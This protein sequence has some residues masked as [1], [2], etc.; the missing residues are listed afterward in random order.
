MSRRTEQVAKLLTQVVGE[1]VLTELSDPRVS[2][3]VTITGAKISSDLRDAIVYFS[4]IGNR[5]EWDSIAEVLNNAAGF[6]QRIVA[7][8]ITLKVT[9]RLFFMPDHTME[10]AQKIE[11]I[12]ASSHLDDISV[13]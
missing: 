1:I 10:Q 3:P 2:G 7:Q 13:S 5:N 8:K 11:D 12:I 6:I 9:P 4:I